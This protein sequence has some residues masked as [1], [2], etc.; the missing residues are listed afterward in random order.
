MS[1]CDYEGSDDDD[2]WACQWWWDDDNNDD[3]VVTHLFI[4]AL[5]DFQS[6]LEHMGSSNKGR[7]KL[8][9][10]LPSHLTDLFFLLIKLNISTIFDSLNL[11]FHPN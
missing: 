11:S 3:D 6:V 4:A 2:Y 8:F 1:R 10:I 7:P 5:S 9:L